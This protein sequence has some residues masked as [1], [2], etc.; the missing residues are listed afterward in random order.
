M[1]CRVRI[2][3]SASC[4]LF[5]LALGSNQFAYAQ[6]EVENDA[7]GPDAPRH[8]IDLTGVFL[9][10]ETSDSLNGLVSYAYNVTENSNLTLTT[11][12]L[13][14]NLDEGGNSGFGDLVAAYS[15]V[16][17]VKIGVNPWVP[18]TVGSGLAVL[19]P[20]GNAKE[21][22]S[23]DTWVVFPFLGLVQP[24]SDRLFIAPQIGYLHSLDATAAGTKL[25]LV[26]AEMGFSFVAFNGFWAS[27]FP[28]FVRDLETDDWAISHRLSVGKKLSQ[29]F[30]ISVDYVFVDQYSFGNDAP[31]DS[32]FDKQL[33]ANFHFIF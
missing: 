13:D 31:Q 5:F 11:P 30:G 17:S 26:T 21:N 18:R 20:T 1:Y 6:D 19:I 16:P 24:L 7:D 4:T 28:Q 12:Y 33:E 9:N 15:I 29:K 22:R 14:P 8:R 23:L 25:R 3:A 27:Y 32:G 2:L 10:G